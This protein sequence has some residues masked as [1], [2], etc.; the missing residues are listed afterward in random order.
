[1]NQN[2]FMF[3]GLTHN[4]IE[5]ILCRYGRP[6]GNLRADGYVHVMY[7]RQRYYAHRI[8]WY[9]ENG[10]FPDGVI[11]HIDHNRSNNKIENLRDVTHAE[12]LKNCSLSKR[13]TSGVCG[14]SFDKKSQ[15]WRAYMRINNK[16]QCLGT[17]D[18]I[19]EAAK[20]REAKQKEMNYHEF[21]GLG[22]IV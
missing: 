3:S 14:V 8:I 18:T 20:L 12:N 11:D 2:L 1:L 21:H 10:K 6:A 13:N 4:K 19:E 17:V 5:G 9:L 15:K 16:N 22:V 7:N